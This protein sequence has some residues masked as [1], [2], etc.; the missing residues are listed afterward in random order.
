MVSEAEER[1]INREVF[2]KPK[3]KKNNLSMAETLAI[4][5]TVTESAMP[6][7]MLE[8]VETGSNTE[9]RNA[10]GSMGTKAC[11]PLLKHS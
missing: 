10:V 5:Q 7:A 8:A 6:K 2:S 3:N 1:K 11:G 9:Q 4:T